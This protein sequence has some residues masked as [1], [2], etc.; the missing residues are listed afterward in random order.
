MFLSS[1]PLRALLSSEYTVN[2]MDAEELRK[3]QRRLKNGTSSKN[4]GRQLS[5]RSDHVAS[6]ESDIDDDLGM[7]ETPTTPG[8]EIAD[9][10]YPSSVFSVRYVRVD[11]RVV[12]VTSAPKSPSSLYCDELRF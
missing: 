10:N 1:S 6:Q 3:S 11:L 9:S 5:S 2:A 4:L 12:K 8:T 7:D